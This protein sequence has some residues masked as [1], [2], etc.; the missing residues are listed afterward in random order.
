M[1]ALLLAWGAAGAAGINWQKSYAD[2]L[3]QA[4]KLDRPVMFI[5]SSHT[6]RYCVILEKETLS[7]PAVVKDLNKDFVSA[8]AYTDE[9]AL[10]PSE[11][12]T[13]G[14][15]TIWFLKPSGEPMFQ[16]IMGAWDVEPFLEALGVVT[17]EYAKTKK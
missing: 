8:I 13:G 4:K 1:M 2:A 11:L 3:V 10:I 5:V 15:P 9:N 12:L 6:C 14:T 7:N 16:P 17:K